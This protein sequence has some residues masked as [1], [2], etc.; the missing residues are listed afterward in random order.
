VVTEGHLL[1]SEGS[2]VAVRQPKPGV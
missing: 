1:L 2:Q